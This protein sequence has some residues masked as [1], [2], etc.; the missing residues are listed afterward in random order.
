LPISEA[1]HSDVYVVDREQVEGD[2]G[3]W[4]LRCELPPDGG[5][6]VDHALLEGTEVEPFAGPHD[7]LAVENAVPVQ[8]RVKRLVDIGELAGQVGSVARPKAD[9]AVAANDR[10]PAS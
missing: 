2:V 9:G 5:G 8:L 1:H 6:S 10:T 4:S 7:Q 3:G